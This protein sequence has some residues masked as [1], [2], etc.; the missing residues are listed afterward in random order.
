[1]TR[2][3]IK[4]LIEHGGLLDDPL[5]DIRRDVRIALR[6]AGAAA[7]FSALHILLEFIM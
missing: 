7:L 1:M 5:T 6:V 4:Y 2:Q 3:R